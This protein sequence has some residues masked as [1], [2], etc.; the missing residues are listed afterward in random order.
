VA[1]GSERRKLG[2]MTTFGAATADKRNSN[3]CGDVVL[4]TRTIFEEYA[5]TTFGTLTARRIVEDVAE[6]RSSAGEDWQQLDEADKENAI[7]EGLLGGV[8]YLDAADRKRKELPFGVTEVFPRLKLPTGQRRQQ[9]LVE[10]TGG[11]QGEDIDS[12]SSTSVSTY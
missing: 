9:V 8:V 6:I 7:D 12:A 2:V 4:D 5:Y 11:S 1:E 3:Q 10:D